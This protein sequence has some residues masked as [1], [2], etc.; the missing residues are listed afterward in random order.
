MNRSTPYSRSPT[1]FALG[2]ILVIFAVAWFANLGVRGLFIPDEGRYAEIAREML[3]A[4]DWI[5]PRLND[6]KYFEKPPLQYWLTAATF[7]LFGQ[8]EWTARF[9]PALLGFLAIAIVGFTANRL[10]NARAGFLAAA[11]LGSNWAFYLSGQYLTLDM[12]L[13]AFLT[14]SLCSFLLA[15]RE[16]ASAKEN[17]YW[18]LVAWAS[19]A[20][21]V[22]SKGLI[23]VVIPAIALVSYTAFTRNFGVWRRLHPMAGLGMLL[24][25]TLPWFVLVQHHNPEFFQFFFVQEHFQRFAQNGHSRAGPIWYYLPIVLIGFMPWTPALLYFV[26]RPRTSANQDDNPRPAHFSVTAFCIAWALSIIVFFS[27]SHS[28]LP[29]YVIPA[30]PAVALLLAHRFQ[31]VVSVFKWC[32]WIT[33]CIGGLMLFGVSRLPNWSKFVAIGPDGIASLAW[34][35]GAAGM[36]VV[37]G[38]LGAWLASRARARMGMAFGALI[39]GA[40]AF[41]TL[42]FQFLDRTEVHFSA[43]HLGEQLARSAKPFHAEL[44]FYSVGQFD[45]SLPFY[46]GRT[47]TLVNVRGEL[48]PGIEA[49]PHKAIATIE[50]FKNIWMSRGE[51]AFAVMTPVQFAEFAQQGL[52]MSLIASDRRLVVVSR[53]QRSMP[54]P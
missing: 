5:T 38:L 23:G 21:A 47:V 12:T 35:Y 1:I 50:Q 43:H 18:M 29:A 15:Q 20:L 4:G 49:E 53:L 28:K 40:F 41:W 22:L 45:H 39:I 31:N 3:A 8:D 6:L 36:L 2:A 48:G 19:A 10:W 9:P 54:A 44:P 14:L 13:S 24:L 33:A 11:I 17:F 25:V 30:F 46:L 7:A 16:Q 34:L 26:Y 37:S 52:P 32:A 42:V 51:Q 27:V